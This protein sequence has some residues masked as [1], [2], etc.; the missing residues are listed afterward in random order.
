MQTS[1]QGIANRAAREKRHRFQNLFILL[2][3]ES[4]KECWRDIRKNA[5]HG[6]DGLSARDYE[7]NLEDNIKDLVRRLKGRRYRAKLVRRT[8]IPKT[9]GKRR[10]LGI[11][12]I[13]DKLLQLAVAR[14]LQAIYEPT[15][16]KCSYGYRPKVGA[17]DAVEKLT[18]MMQ[19]RRCNWIVDADIRSYFDTIDHDWMI[20]MLEERIDD[21]PLLQLITKWL[22]AGVL[23][24]DGGVIRPTTGT[25]Q[26]GVI[27]PILANV[28]LHYALDLWFQHIF[29][30]RCRGEAYLVRY[31]D[32]FVCAFQSEDEAKLFYSEIGTRLDKFKLKL[33]DEKSRLIPFSRLTPETSKRFEFLGFEYYLGKSRSGKN[34]VKR[35]TSR[36][37]LRASLKRF[38]EWCKAYRRIK[39]RKLFYYLNAKFRGYYNYYGVIGNYASIGEFH[40][41]AMKILFKWLNRRSQRR[42]Y[43]WN[44]FNQMLK[45]FNVARPRIVGRSNTSGASYGA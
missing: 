8:Y 22:K 21:R 27:S 37:K 2:N 13:E 44:G 7:A 3:E 16:L 29:K 6:V 34:W 33:S 31:A 10:P 42:S 19:F 39:L 4:L 5:A 17:H 38:T 28:Y 11:P 15:F 45:D 18:N 40:Y 30:K 20:R 9:D 25:P 12:A 24:T 14:I 26:G 36:K 43:N 35:R 23:E 1:L 32:D 41:R